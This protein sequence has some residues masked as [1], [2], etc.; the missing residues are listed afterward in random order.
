M[1][2]PGEDVLDRQ[3]AM[4]PPAFPLP[5]GKPGEIRARKAPA[6]PHHEREPGEAVGGGRAATCLGWALLAEVFS[7]PARS[8]A[9]GGEPARLSGADSHRFS[10]ARWVMAPPPLPSPCVTG[11]VMLGTSGLPLAAGGWSCSPCRRRSP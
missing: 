6:S 9:P 11:D 2:P 8:P 3:R 5:P 10:A 7:L 4:E 1:F